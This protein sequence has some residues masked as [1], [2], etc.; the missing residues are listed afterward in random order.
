MRRYGVD[1]DGVSEIA[2]IVSIA[3]GGV[4]GVG[5]VSYIA[6]AESVFCNTLHGVSECAFVG[7]SVGSI[8]ASIMA[9]GGHGRDA[10]QLY[11][12]HLGG[13]FGTKRIRGRMGFGALYDDAYV[14]EVL[15]KEFDVQLGDINAHLFITA[16][17][18]VKRDIKVFSTKDENDKKTYLW[19]AV[20]ASM[21]AP[22]YFSPVGPYFDGGLCANDPSMVGCDA[23]RRHYGSDKRYKVAR[24]VT[25]GKQPDSPKVDPDEFTAT[26]L[27]KRLIPA[28]TQG[29][30]ANVGYSLA[31]NG[32]DVFTIRPNMRDYDL[33]DVN[34]YPECQGIWESEFLRTGRDFCNWWR[35]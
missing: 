9:L 35:T 19:Y 1:G 32:H 21:A 4:G 7:N 17:D 24:F 5:P 29:N 31:A 3:G 14:N 11:D 26:L 16:W 27:K 22:T 33:A 34:F 30:S 6:Q 15:K 28:L 13:I 10:L 25:S 12:K 20:R 23:M 18:A 2:H 8:N